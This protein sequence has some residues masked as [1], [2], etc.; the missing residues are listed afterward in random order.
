MSLRL[1]WV[2]LF[3]ASGWS[4]NSWFIPSHTLCQK[5]FQMT[6]S[7][8]VSSETFWFTSEIDWVMTDE[9]ILCIYSIQQCCCVMCKISSWFNQYLHEYCQILLWYDTILCDKI[10]TSSIPTNKVKQRPNFKL[11][12]T[13]H[14]SPIR[15]SYGVSFMST[16]AKTDCVIKP[17]YYILFLKFRF[18]TVKFSVRWSSVPEGFVG[19]ME[20][21]CR[22]L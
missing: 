18:R 19:M 3:C 1:K 9:A 5:A 13:P 20:I 7:L 11:T 6:A 8:T 16:L 12:K 4:V 22:I 10:I 14:S 15:A 21:D 2:N 17:T